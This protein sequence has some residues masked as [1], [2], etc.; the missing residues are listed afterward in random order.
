M[1]MQFIDGLIM[2]IITAA[3]LCIGFVMKKWLPT[4]DK[5]IPTVLLILGA[6]S[7]LILFGC[8][9][10]GIVKG[11]VSGLAAVGLHQAFKQHLKLPMGEDEFY[12]MGKGDYNEDDAALY[13][14]CASCEEVSDDE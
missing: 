10:E 9:Y 6:V 14:D 3:A 4:D 8:D 7:G 12:A 13:D 1:Q 11:M 2:P 5:W